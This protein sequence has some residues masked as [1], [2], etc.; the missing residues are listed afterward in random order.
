VLDTVAGVE[1]RQFD[2]RPPKE[3]HKHSDASCQIRRG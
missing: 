1:M 3:I 2:I